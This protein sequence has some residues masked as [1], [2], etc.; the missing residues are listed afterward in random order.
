MFAGFVYVVFG[1]HEGSKVDLGH[2]RDVKCAYARIRELIAAD[3][4]EGLVNT[5]GD[6]RVWQT[7]ADFLA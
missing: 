5:A 3:R 2:Y 6:Y 7:T 1:T 4:D